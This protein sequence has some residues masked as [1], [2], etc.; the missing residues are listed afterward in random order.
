MAA[1]L[2][3]DFGMTGALATKAPTTAEPARTTPLQVQTTVYVLLRVTARP[4]DQISA[5]PQLS[6]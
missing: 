2:E 6:G 3:L 5:L 1:V 4:M